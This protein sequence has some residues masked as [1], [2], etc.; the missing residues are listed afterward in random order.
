MQIIDW[1]AALSDDTLA[2]CL[3]AHRGALRDGTA[4]NAAMSR[5][6]ITAIHAELGR[7]AAADYV[8]RHYH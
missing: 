7:R 4:D 3:A 5:E 6:L 8:T 1:L 2:R